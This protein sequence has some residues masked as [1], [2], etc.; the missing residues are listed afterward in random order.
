MT[1]FVNVYTNPA[2]EDPFFSKPH[3]TANDAHQAR[4]HELKDEPTTNLLFVVEIATTES[5]NP[6]MDYVATLCGDDEP[7]AYYGPT[8]QAAVQDLIDEE[9]SQ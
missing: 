6:E 5:L 1:R 2:I 9:Y 8:W 3:A 7:T 4:L